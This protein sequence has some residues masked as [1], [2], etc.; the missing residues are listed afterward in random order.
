MKPSVYLA[1]PITGLS[2][3][4]CTDWRKEVRQQLEPEIIAYSPLRSK[5]YLVG[6]TSLADSYDRHVLSTQRGIYTRDMYDC[7]TRDLIFVNF[8]GAQRVSIGT[9]MEIAWAAAFHKP[10]VLVMEKENNIHEHSMIREASPLRTDNLEEGIW[11]TKALLL[12]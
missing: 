8:L 9:V 1:G 3:D 4:S 10:V 5:T 6:E 12:P 7:R 2:F 11:L